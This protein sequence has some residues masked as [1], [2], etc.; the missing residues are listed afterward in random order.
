MPA[1]HAPQAAV[2]RDNHAMHHRGMASLLIA[3]GLTLVASCTGSPEASAPASDA[4]TSEPSTSPS[5]SVGS[6][7]PSTVGNPTTDPSAA[8][9]QTILDDA[10]A[11]MLRQDSVGFTSDAQN[12]IYGD[13]TR[14]TATGVWTRKPLAWRAT[15]K[16]DGLIAGTTLIGGDATV[17]WIY[18]SSQPRRV[19]YRFTPK[20]E[21]PGIWL[22]P[23][24]YG[25]RPGVSRDALTT[26]PAIYLVRRAKAT[27]ASFNGDTVAIA[28]TI[29]TPAALFELGLQGHMNDLGYAERLSKSRTRVLVTIGAD[30]LPANL[31][32]TGGGIQ[33][34]DL[35]LP[36]YVVE[37]FAGARYLAEYGKANLK[38]PIKAPTLS[39]TP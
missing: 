12:V 17:D 31:E 19:W 29:P 14:T 30:G 20:G 2:T 8:E 26:P 7:N 18:V 25:V 21:K 5:S 10:V 27:A 32:F 37:E 23:P 24:G 34:A 4:S 39:P 38:G 33:V 11:A 1:A 13:V 35:D 16:Y 15:T 28:G 6:G 36:D 9:A 3:A 22:A